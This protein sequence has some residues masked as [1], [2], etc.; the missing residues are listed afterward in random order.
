MPYVLEAAVEREIGRAFPPEHVDYVKRRLSEQELSLGRSAHPAR[1]HVAVV[2]LAR[3]DVGRFD[4]ALDGAARDWR[5]AL[6]AAGLAHPDWR[7]VLAQRGIDAH[8]W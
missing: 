6:V 2:W 1:V 4:Q 7:A 3:G 5:D 8:D